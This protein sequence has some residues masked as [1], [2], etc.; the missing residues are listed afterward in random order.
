MENLDTTGTTPPAYEAF[1][2]VPSF[3]DHFLLNEF[4]KNVDAYRISAFLYK[5]KD[6]NGGKL[7]AGPIWDFNLSF[8][9]AW[10]GE[11]YMVTNTWQVDYTLS[12]R[13]YDGYRVPF[14]WPVLVRD[15]AFVDILLNRWNDLKKANLKKEYVYTII[16]NLVTV[17]TEARERNTARWPEMGDQ[18]YDAEIANMKQWINDRWDWM[19]YNMDLLP[20]SVSNMSNAYQ[21]RLQ[22]NYPNPFNPSTTISYK[23]L[24]KA[25][26][27]LIIYNCIGQEVARLN[28]GIK[29]PGY[30]PVEFDATDLPCGLYIYQLKANNYVTHKKMLLI[31]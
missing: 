12:I 20:S 24:S 3:V 21:F 1:I 26:V 7:Y 29:S 2:D 13:P 28:E 9:N 30:Y 11:D 4:C 19:N 16:D 23:I 10:F 8:G 31:R 15:R 18:D 25:Q 17:M 22:Q 27:E 14:W 5:D 6:S